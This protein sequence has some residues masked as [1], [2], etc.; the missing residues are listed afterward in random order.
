MTN[1]TRINDQ[2]PNTTPALIP[3]NAA[4]SAISTIPAPQS[5]QKMQRSCPTCREKHAR[6]SPECKARYEAQVEAA[7]GHPASA[8]V[9]LMIGKSIANVVAK[10][11][12]QDAKIK[13]LEGEVVEARANAQQLEQ[14]HR[15]TEENVASLKVSEEEL[16]TENNDLR[17][18]VER[19]NSE[20]ARLNRMLHTDQEVEVAY[21]LAAMRHSAR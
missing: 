19:L 13:H 5:G 7:A 21:A 11:A 16:R 15:G 17:G 12:G 3:Q 8:F 10:L 6:C 14:I 9:T 2:A 1:R 20:L 4:S 18:E